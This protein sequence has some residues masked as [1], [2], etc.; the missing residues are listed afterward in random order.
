MQVMENLTKEKEATRDHFETVL[1]QERLAAE[2]REFGLKKV[3]SS[4]PLLWDGVKFRVSLE[5]SQS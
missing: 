4:A 3:S 2:D 1:E 5:A